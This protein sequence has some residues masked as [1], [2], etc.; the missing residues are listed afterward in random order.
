MDGLAPANVTTVPCP[1]CGELV[2]LPSNGVRLNP[3][4]G[5]FDEVERPWH[6]MI[7][8]PLAMAAVGGVPTDE[9]VFY[10]MHEHQPEEN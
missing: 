1:E 7:L 6:L 8:G 4:M 2:L 3:G 5:E 9:P 10:A